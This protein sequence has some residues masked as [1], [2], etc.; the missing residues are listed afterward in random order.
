MQML[1]WIFGS[2]FVV[3]LISQIICAIATVAIAKAACK[4][5]KEEDD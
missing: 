1:Y 3:W 4:E 2:L 5:A